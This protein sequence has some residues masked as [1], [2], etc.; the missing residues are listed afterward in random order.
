[1]IGL[2]DYNCPK[3]LHIYRA[4]LFIT[5]PGVYHLDPRVH[6]IDRA[7]QHLSD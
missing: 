1:M 6:S 7:T 4:P 2:I 3:G 5:L